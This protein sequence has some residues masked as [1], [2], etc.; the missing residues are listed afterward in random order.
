[1]TYV[2]FDHFVLLELVSLYMEWKLL[3]GEQV[4]SK[5][6]VP[7]LSL[8]LSLFIMLLEGQLLR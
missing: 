6:W 7:D 8:C 3:R 4:F 2:L 5:T 1:M